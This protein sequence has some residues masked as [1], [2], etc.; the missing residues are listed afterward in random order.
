MRRGAANYLL[1]TNVVSEWVKPS[2]DS[3][4]ITWLAEVD[5]DRVFLSVATF[6]ELRHGIERLPSSRRR[7]QLTAWLADDLPAR[8][9]KRILDID[10]KVADRWGVTIAR[11]RAAGV[12]MSTMD[13]FFAATA[14]A[15]DLTLVTRDVHDFREAGITLFNPWKPT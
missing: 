9:E 7:E 12:T 5:E 2:P 10:R 3:D 1:D 14:A 15:H 6:A 11:C 4:V 13:A 8:F